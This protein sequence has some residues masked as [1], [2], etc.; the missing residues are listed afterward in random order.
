[1]SLSRGDSTE[2]LCTKSRGTR[3]S[4]QFVSWV[5]RTYLKMCKNSRSIKQVITLTLH[6]LP[7]FVISLACNLGE[8]KSHRACY[9]TCLFFSLLVIPIFFSF[10]Y[11]ETCSD[12]SL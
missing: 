2:M 8:K 4:V 12:L 9:S 1:M 5:L 7:I 10:G 3:V 6:F 11:R